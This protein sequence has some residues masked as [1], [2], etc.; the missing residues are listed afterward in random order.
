MA[1]LM[2]FNPV[3]F[4]QTICVERIRQLIGP[5][6]AELVLHLVKD[7]M[8]VEIILGKDLVA[9]GCRACFT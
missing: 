6:W 5:N 1:S 2:R 7:P 3:K 9:F 4:L 8:L